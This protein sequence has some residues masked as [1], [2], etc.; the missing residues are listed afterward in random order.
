[1]ERTWMPKAAGVLNLVAGVFFLIGGIALAG[2]PGTP[3][4]EAV[5]GYVE[6]SLGSGVTPSLVTMVI[7]IL[8]AWLIIL[9]IISALGGVYALKRS[10]W[11]LA[12]AGSIATLIYFTPLGIPAIIFTA[13]AKKEFT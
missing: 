12:L 4:A 5:A 1:M 9:G 10:L 7:S 8:S 13:L 3:M 11:G 6:Y 2:L